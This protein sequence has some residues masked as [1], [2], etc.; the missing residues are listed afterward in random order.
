[1]PLPDLHIAQGFLTADER[2]V[3][4]LAQSDRFNA[5]E[6]ERIVG[7]FGTRPAGIPCPLAHFACPFE[8]DRVAVVTAA[9]RPDGSLGFRFL[10][11][12]RELYRHLGD[13]FAIADRYPP[14]W[15][16][17]G[18]LPGL[19]WP[20]EPLPKRRVEDLH[21]ILKTGDTSLLLGGVQALVDG[22]VVLVKRSAPDEGLLRG[23]WQLLPDRSRIDLW[24]ASFAFSN[25]L[26]FHAAVLPELPADPH[27][28]RHTEDGLRDYPQ[29]RYEL[30]L[31]IA[32]E[33]GDQREVDRLF[34]RRTS[35]DTIRLGLTILAL[36]AALA[37]I[38]K[39]MF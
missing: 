4:V 15:N 28:R 32:I 5:A 3:R 21:E 8:G 33:A 22:S 1:M 2:G 6:A 7:L 14:D 16:A 34:R 9:D 29:S 12:G 36:A 35:D 11:L 10:T 39:L 31:Q 19:E 30:H 38:S 24:P 23:L 25:D 17:R 37:V 13:P 20:A 27:R 18:T 26:G